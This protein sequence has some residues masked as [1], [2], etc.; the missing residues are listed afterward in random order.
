MESRRAAIFTWLI[1]ALAAASWIFFARQS[2]REALRPVDAI[3]PVPLSDWSPR[4]VQIASLGHK[5]IYDDF[6]NLWLMQVIL[7]PNVKAHPEE[8]LK[9]IRHAIRHRP[10][11]ESLYMLACFTALQDLKKP[12]ACQE[13]TLAGLEVFPQSWRLPMTQ[14]FIHAFVLNEP[15]SGAKFYLLAA[16]RPKSPPYVA[17]VAEKLAKKEAITEE[18]YE[19]SLEIMMGGEHNQKFREFLERY[20]PQVAVNPEEAQHGPTN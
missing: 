9:V 18:D 16:S 17:R 4:A 7:E 8:T 11:L 5:H 15:L 19:K 10:A 14:G 1:F 12:E 6:L 2:S 3:S 20:R 13:I